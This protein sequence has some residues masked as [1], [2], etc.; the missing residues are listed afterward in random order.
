MSE[1]AATWSGGKDSCLAVW[2]AISQGLTVS[3]LLN[4][5]NKDSTK[6]MSHSLGYKLIAMQAEATGMPI[7]QQK[8]TKG[9]YETGFK[10]ALADLKS[11]GITRLITG[12]I[13]LQAHKDWIDRVCRESG[14]EA[15]LPLWHLDTSQLLMDFIEAGFKAVV[16][17]TRAEK[18][19]KEWLGRQVDKQLAVEL[20]GLN[21]DP[22]GEEGEFHTFVYDGPIFKKPINLINSRPVLRDN[23]WFLDISE[24][25]LG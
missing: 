23:R 11:K 14:I 21:I 3:Y 5:V 15:V 20:K 13:Y 7:I 10:T 12:D 1:H 2:K 24:Y 18:L 9:T 22:C 19:G 25:R 8:V 16:V 17:S 6:S 4:F